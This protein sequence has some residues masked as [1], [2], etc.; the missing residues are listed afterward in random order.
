MM[1]TTYITNQ[2]HA[3]LVAH[4]A[5]FGGDD[6]IAAQLRT[7]KNERTRARMEQSEIEKQLN[8]R[9]LTVSDEVLDW[10]AANLRHEIEHGAPAQVRA[11]IHSVIQRL[12]LRADDTL[13]IQY[14]AE[15]VLRA[16]T[17]NR[18]TSLRSAFPFDSLP[19]PGA[20]PAHAQLYTTHLILSRQ[21]AARRGMVAH[22]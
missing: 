13:H 4:I 14:T 11:V 15:P 22:V 21:R 3:H 5:R 19:F 12:D 2:I 7:T 1:D 17:V 8:A 16:L 10:L 20:V 9:R 18:K 6:E